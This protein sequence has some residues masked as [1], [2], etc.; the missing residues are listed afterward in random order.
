M[1]QALI[2][3]VVMFFVGCIISFALINSMANENENLKHELKKTCVD[4]IEGDLALFKLCPLVTSLVKHTSDSLMVY[5]KD[6]KDKVLYIITPRD[7]CWTCVESILEVLIEKV[8]KSGVK[9]IVVT[10]NGIF[11]NLNVFSLNKDSPFIILNADET[12]YGKVINKEITSLLLAF[13]DIE[14]DEVRPFI[15]RK[16]YSPIDFW[17]MLAEESIISNLKQ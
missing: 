10:S 11:R 13:H 15:E 5:N 6:I 3:T 17:E 9:L 16:S 7:A 8:N 1:K 2:I 12:K 4:E 14:S